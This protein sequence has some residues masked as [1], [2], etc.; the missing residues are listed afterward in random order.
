MAATGI[1]IPDDVMRIVDD[2]KKEWRTDR[3]KALVRVILE[4]AKC[5]DR[6]EPTRQA[7]KTIPSLAA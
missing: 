2:A 6:P 4:W 3:S 1:S 7:E 5:Y